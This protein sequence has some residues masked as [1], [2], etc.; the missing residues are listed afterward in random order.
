MLTI[1]VLIILMVIAMILVAFMVIGFSVIVDFVLSVIA[2]AL[3]IVTP[4]YVLFKILTCG[5]KK[6]VNK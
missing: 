1:L 6:K 5:R 4:F 2:A 3:F